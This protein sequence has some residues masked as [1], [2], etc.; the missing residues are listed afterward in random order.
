MA[1]R[2]IALRKASGRTGMNL[3]TAVGEKYSG[4]SIVYAAFVGAN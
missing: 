4:I 1:A 3:K 2:A